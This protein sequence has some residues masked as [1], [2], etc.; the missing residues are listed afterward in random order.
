MIPSRRAARKF[1]I[2]DGDAFGNRRADFWHRGA[3]GR[4]SMLMLMRREVALA[5]CAEG[6][7]LELDL[8]ACAAT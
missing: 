5:R 6:V 4:G 8:D 1:D 3:G 7:A 2:F